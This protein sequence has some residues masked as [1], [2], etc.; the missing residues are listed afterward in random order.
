M[1]EDPANTGGGRW[2][3]RLRKGVADRI[4]E[5]VI[6]ALVGERIVCGGES[7][8][9]N[10]AVLSVRKD[11]DILSVWCAPASRPERDGIRYVLLRGS[12]MLR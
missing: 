3:L 9:V 10:G 2:V 6:W 8:K 5:E 7:G 12:C 11:E 1:W 4:W